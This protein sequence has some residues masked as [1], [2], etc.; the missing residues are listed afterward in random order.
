MS[1]RPG[2]DRRTFLR[3]TAATATVAATAPAG[4]A[5]A[6]FVT[7]PLP[8]PQTDGGRP[9]MQALKTRRSSRE[10]RPDPLPPQVLS[11]LLW[12]ASGTNRLETGGRTA[13]S[14]N[15]AQD[16][17][18][19]LIGADGVSVYEPKPHQLRQVLADDLRGLTGGQAFVKEVPLNL[20]YVSDLSRM[21]RAAPEMREFYAAAHTGFVSQNV[22]L[23]CA[24]EGLATVVR[25]MLDRPALAKALSLRPQQKITLAQSV[26]YPK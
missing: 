5:R 16:L 12:A 11:N 25:A 10:F 22:Y 13:P 4:A 8:A 20:V 3:L 17:E 15:N 1:P 18:I 19:Y 7:G 26:G 24:S 21:V 14:A 6:G 2:M 9:L 23:Y